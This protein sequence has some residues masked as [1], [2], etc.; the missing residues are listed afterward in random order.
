MNSDVHCQGE[1]LVRDVAFKA[2]KW[3]LSVFLGSV[4]NAKGPRLRDA[5]TKN[6]AGSQF[7]L[8]SS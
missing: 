7:H 2:K 5:K 4:G 3:T 6:K 1:G 8:R